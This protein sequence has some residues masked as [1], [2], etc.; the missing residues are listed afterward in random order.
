M[1]SNNSYLPIVV[2]VDVDDTDSVKDDDWM[3]VSEEF[4]NRRDDLLLLS[5]SIECLVLLVGIFETVSSSSPSFMLV[6]HRIGTSAY[7]NL[8]LATSSS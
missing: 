3:L 4:W 2:V 1:A 7:T 8:M 5:K 6:E